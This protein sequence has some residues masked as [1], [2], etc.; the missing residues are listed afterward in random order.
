MKSVMQSL[1]RSSL[2]HPVAAALADRQG[3][4][5]APAVRSLNDRITISFSGN[6]V[7][8]STT[9]EQPEI[10]VRNPFIPSSSS[11]CRLADLV[12]MTGMLLIGI[13]AVLL[14]LLSKVS[15]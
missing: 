8:V 3:A 13:T 1:R 12:M 11:V 15:L 2:F 14:A 7:R 4:N 5:I 9:K 10:D 6:Q